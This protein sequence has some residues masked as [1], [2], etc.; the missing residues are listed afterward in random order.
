MN[1]YLLTYCL[2]LMIN[3]SSSQNGVIEINKNHLIDTLINLKKEISKNTYNLK[4]QIYSGKRD[5]A[6]DLINFYKK[7]DLEI[8]IEIVYE[9]PN[10]KVWIGNYYS[11]LEADRELLKIKKRHPEAFI[12][13]PK[14]KN[15]KEL[16][17]E[18]ET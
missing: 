18:N 7:N 12:F 5:K 8:D 3:L 2:V 17:T 1:K 4:I 6:I 10:Y 9:T 14:P 11:Q 15:N 13:R 16:Q